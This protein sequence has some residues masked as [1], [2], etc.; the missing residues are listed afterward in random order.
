[1]KKLLALVLCVM[2]F[3]AVIPT[4]A[5]A[6]D[7]YPTVEK[8]LDPAATYAK[9]IKNMI[10]NSRDSIED[11]YATIVMD[12]TVYNTAKAMDDTVVGLVEALTK[13]MIGQDIMVRTGNA[14]FPVGKSKFTKTQA[15]AVKD[16]VRHLVDSLVAKEM[17][18]NSYKYYNGKDFFILDYA[19]TFA[20]AVSKALTN[21][22]FQKGYEAVATYFAVTKLMNDVNK[23]I[24][25]QYKAF[26]SEV[27]GTGFDK[28]FAKNYPELAKSYIDSFAEKYGTTGATIGIYAPGVTTA[29][30]A[31]AP[32]ADPQFIGI[33]DYYDL[34]K[35]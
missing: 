21:K 10:K 6:A 19:Q 8:P 24:E 25:D 30:E 14:D 12:K 9:E 5:F 29:I 23:E 17:A 3:V 7:T 16:G 11:A 15:D 35:D 13:N 32:W 2:M 26:R 33:P 1:M 18:D 27:E 20:N 22:D 4:S 34:L 28:D 31:T